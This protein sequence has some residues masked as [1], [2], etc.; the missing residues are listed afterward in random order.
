[1]SVRKKTVVKPIFKLDSYEKSLEDNLNDEHLIS[2]PDV[3]KEKELAQKAASSYIKKEARINIRLSKID[4]EKIK[5]KAVYE[6]LPYQTLIAS[7]LHK[8]ACIIN[9]KI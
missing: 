8:Y 4:L 1:M 7:V 2:I 5:E 3:A 6:G 9:N